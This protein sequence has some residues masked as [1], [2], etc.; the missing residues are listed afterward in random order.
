MIHGMGNKGNLNLLFKIQQKGLPRPLVL[1]F[2]NPSF[3]ILAFSFW[4]KARELI[5]WA[6]G[7]STEQKDYPLS[8]RFIH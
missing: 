6:Q 3:V 7:L 8:K 1:L 5:P 4:A 2:P